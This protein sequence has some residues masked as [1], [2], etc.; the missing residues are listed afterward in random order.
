MK[1]LKVLLKGIDI[2]EDV[3]ELYI[4]PTKI[5]DI[6]VSWEIELTYNDGSKQK[7]PGKDIQFG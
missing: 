2:S 1:K 5:N 7:F 6:S 3:K 4:I